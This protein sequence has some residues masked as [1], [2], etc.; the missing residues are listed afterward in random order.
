MSKPKVSVVIPIWNT[1]KYLEKCLESILNQT[2]RDIEIICVNNGSTDSCSKII[3]KFASSESRIKVVHME[4]GYISDARNK[5]LEYAQGEYLY[6]CDSDDWLELHALESW[7]TKS[8][9]HDADLCILQER[10][11]NRDEKKAVSLEHRI[12]SLYGCLEDK[13][14]TYKDMKNLFLE[15]YE[16]W[17]HFYKRE[18]YIN[19][20]LYYPPKTF[21]EDVIMHFK[22]IF[23]AK[24][25]VFC[26]EPLYN[27]LFRSDSSLVMSNHTLEKL[28]AITY[29]KDLY[30]LLCDLN[31]ADEYLSE[32][33]NMILRQMYFHLP[34]ANTYNRKKLVSLFKNFVKQTPKV[35]K[36]ILGSKDYYSR[37]KNILRKELPILSDFVFKTSTHRVFKL[38]PIKV[39]FRYKK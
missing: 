30:V 39:R 23:Y 24:K 18:F 4:H 7:Y 29:F 5:G 34:S 26:F 19:E 15:R 6:F 33:T 20:N 2:L 21:Y 14:Y 32:Y 35:E 8:K 22:S 28:D 38:G 36:C 25:I 11:F 10:S 27:H 17:L 13:A 31:L 16:A 1:E 3:S 37:Y 12:L 9:K